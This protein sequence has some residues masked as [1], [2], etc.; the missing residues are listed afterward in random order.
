MVLAWIGFQCS[1]MVG[2]HQTVAALPIATVRQVRQLTP[3]DAALAHPVHLSGVITA[4]SGYRNS[5]FLQD[6]TAGISVDRT[7]F[8][9]AHVGDRVEV[10]GVS[11]PGFFAPVVIASKVLVKGRASLPRAVPVT[12][13]DVVGGAEDSQRVE[14]RGIVRSANIKKV[15]DHTAL[16][17][18]LDVG[19]SAVK[20]VL[21]AFAGVHYIHLIDAAVRVRGVCATEFNDRRQFVGVSLIVPAR[22]DFDVLHAS[23]AEPFAEPVVSAR[24]AFR[25]GQMAHRIKVSGTITWILPNRGFYLQQGNDGIRVQTASREI[26][27]L[28]TAIEAVGFPAMGEYAPVLEDAIFRPASRSSPVKPQFIEA[29]NVINRHV[30]FNR[31]KYDGQLVE[32]RG[33][34]VNS[35]RGGSEDVFLLRQ[36]EELFEAHLNRSSADPVSHIA[37]GSEV[38]LTGICVISSD[39]DRNPASFVILL[40]SPSDIAILKAASWWTTGHTIRA[41]ELAVALTCCVLWWVWSLKSQV[42]KQTEQ[43]RSQLKEAAALR[44]LAEVATRSKSEFLA[45]MSHEIRTPMNGVLGM[46]Q[47]LLLTELSEEQRHFSEVAQS[48]GRTLLAVIDDVL[49]ISKIEAS[50][51]EIECLEFNLRLAL[52][53]ITEVWRI[54]AGTKNLDFRSRLSADVPTIVRGDVNRLRQVLNNL[55]SNAIKFTSRGKIVL[56]VAVAGSEDGK[57]AVRFAVTDTGIGL[58][59]DQ[60][61]KLFSPFV[62]ADASTTRKFGGT[63]LGL[64]IS[65]HLTELM[66]G[67]IGIESREGEGATFWFTVIFETVAA[68]DLGEDEL[69]LGDRSAEVQLLDQVSG[70][71][72]ARGTVVLAAG[73]ATTGRGDEARILVVEDNATNRFV[74][75]AQLSKLGYQAEAVIHGAEAIRALR[76]KAYDLI[77]MDCEMPVMDGYEATRRIRGSG[78][79]R[80]PI[81]ALT[82]HAMAGDRER[83]L[84]EG[85]DD[86]ISKPLDMQH[87]ADVLAKWN[88]AAVPLVK[89]E[90]LPDVPAK[91]PAPVF[92]GEA[93]LNRLMGDR[94]LAEIVLG[95]FIGDF[96]SQMDTLRKRLSEKDGPGVLLQ[97]HSL[98]GSAATVSAVRLSVVAMEME[99]AAH[100]D[101][102][103]LLGN[104]MPRVTEEFEQLR[105]ELKVSG[106]L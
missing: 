11:G 12:Y 23:N 83:C 46:V 98:K 1:A 75:L 59:A 19:G 36:G 25:F 39:A 28:G 49:D 14:F 40:R 79:P 70:E 16:V 82:A 71:S 2:Q 94:Q 60:A 106:W 33:Q 20:L 43:I 85:M 78:G 56:E 5:F 91:P 4:F 87:L 7:D 69:L 42:Q 30:Y 99:T 95:G 65:K 41:L 15:F 80:I 61:A 38:L 26:P 67:C 93:L 102:L 32:L 57:T 81:I 96:P 27:E 68:M 73:P 64:A 62:Q 66:G 31:T 10:T 89:A 104:L 34:I 13:S 90:I 18:I 100:T 17:V 105:R 97:A 6:Q 52:E 101:K 45:N 50:K 37:D 55:A 22:K 84:R 47:L 8:A 103:D 48:S 63:G 58:R 53:E 86:F 77:L 29:G 51:I 9:D 76:H 3:E 72:A 92:D 35:R 88:K 24:D 44:E 54:Q 74:V 21:Q